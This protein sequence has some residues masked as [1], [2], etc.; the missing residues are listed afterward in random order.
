MSECAECARL[1]AQLEV[2]EAGYRAAVS[3]AQW[4]SRT[5]VELNEYERL[6]REGCRPGMTVADRANWIIEVR[7]RVSD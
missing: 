4:Q 6:L 7:A 5:N 1:R 3:K 2:A